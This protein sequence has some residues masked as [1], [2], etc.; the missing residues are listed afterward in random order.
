[1][2]IE[3]WVDDKRI[4]TTDVVM[5]TVY[6]SYAKHFNLPLVFVYP[7]M[8]P[9]VRDPSPYIRAYTTHMRTYSAARRADVF[10]MWLDHT[11]GKDNNIYE[12]DLDK[13]FPETRIKLLLGTADELY[14]AVKFYTY[15]TIKVT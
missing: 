11:L 7:T 8:P 3:F 15:L 5:L 12:I 10:R 14:N 2:G 6:N 9:I 1:M 13:E 4:Y